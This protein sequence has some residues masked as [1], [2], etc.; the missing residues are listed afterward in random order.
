MDGFECIDIHKAKEM[1]D[2]ENVAII[3][4]RDPASFEDAHIEKAV[5]IT[6]QTV[7]SFMKTADKNK[8]LVCYCYHG[9]NSQMAAVYFLENGF[10]HVYSIDGGFEAWRQVYPS[11]TGS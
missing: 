11:V 10:K 9:N 2:R 4:V 1:I 8:P 6:D 7:E 5:F 3:D